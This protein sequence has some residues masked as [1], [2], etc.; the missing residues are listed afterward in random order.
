LDNVKNKLKKLLV[1]ENEDKKS[2]EILERITSIDEDK[3]QSLIKQIS[4]L[5]TTPL[6]FLRMNSEYNEGDNISGRIISM[7]TDYQPIQCDILIKSDDKVFFQGKTNE[8]GSLEF[9]FKANQKKYEVKAIF[10]GAERALVLDLE[11]K[12]NDYVCYVITDKDYYIPGQKILVRVILWKLIGSKYQPSTEPIKIT[13]TDPQ[14]NIILYREISCEPKFGVAELQIPIT[15]EAIQGDYTLEIKV[16]DFESQKKIHIKHYTPPDIELEVECEPEYL[17]IGDKFTFKLKSNYFYGAPVKDGQ[18]KI[19]IIASDS[20]EVLKNYVKTDEKGEHEYNFKVPKMKKGKTEIRV[21]LTDSLNRKASKTIILMALEKAMNVSIDMEKTIEPGQQAEIIVKTE[22]PAL[23]NKTKPLQDCQILATIND[24]ELKHHAKFKMGRTDKEGRC[25][26]IFAIDYPT[27]KKKNFDIN[28]TIE[29]EKLNETTYIRKGLTVQKAIKKEEKEEKLDKKPIDIWLKTNLKSSSLEINEILQFDVSVKREN[30]PVYVEIEKEN[31]IYRAEK[32]AKQG[33]AT[34]E[35]PISRNMWGNLNLV[36][37]AFKENGVLEK[38]QKTLYI[39]PE[40][41]ELKITIESDQPE[42]RPGDKAKF[43]VRVSQ[44]DE[45]MACCLGAMLVDAAVLQLGRKLKNP[46]EIFFKKLISKKQIIELISWSKSEYH[47]NFNDLLDALILHIQQNPKDL[48]ILLNFSRIVQNLHLLKHEDFMTIYEKI[49]KCVQKKAETY[50]NENKMTLIYNIL[51]TLALSKP[52]IEEIEFIE[53]SA[54]EELSLISNENVDLYKAI[55]SDIKLAHKEGFLTNEQKEEISIRVHERAL[56][57]TPRKTSALAPELKKQINEMLEWASNKKAVENL[58]SKYIMRLKNLEKA[59]P[60]DLKEPTGKNIVLALGSDLSYIG[61]AGE[62]APRSIVP[63]LVGYPKYTS[64]MTDVEHYAREFYVG[65]EALSLR[66]GYLLPILPGSTGSDV[67]HESFAGGSEDSL[68]TVVTKSLSGEITQAPMVSVRFHFPETSLWIPNLE[69]TNGEA[70]IETEL[71]DQITSHELTIIA[72]TKECEAGIGTY[73]ATVKQNFF[74][75]LDTPP[76]LTHGD[77]IKIG[78]ILTNLTNS[79]LESKVHLKSDDQILKIEKLNDEI[80]VPANGMNRLDFKIKAVSPGQAVLWIEAKTS[81]YIDVVRKEIKVNPKGE[82]H[83]IRYTGLITEDGIITFSPQIPENTIFYRAHLSL[84]PGYLMGCIDGLESILEYPHGCTEQ[85]MAKFLPNILVYNLLKAKEKITAEFQKKIN[86]YTII[87]IQQ[88][89]SLRNENGGWGYWGNR[90]TVPYITAHVIYSLAYAINS[91]FFIDQKILKNAI[92]ELGK[93]QTKDGIWESYG[94][95]RNFST[96][97]VV[98]A[99]LEAKKAGLSINQ[100][101]I[102]KAIK[103]IL[104]QISSSSEILDDPNTMANI[105]EVLLD[106]NPKKYQKQVEFLIERIIELAKRENAYIYWEKGSA[107]AG[108]VESTANVVIALHL[109]NKDPVLIQ[110]ALNYIMLK[111]SGYGWSTTSDTV[112]AIR[113]LTKCVKSE[114]QNFSLKVDFNDRQVGNYIVNKD[115]IESIIYDMRKI[116]LKDFSTKNKLVLEKKGEG[117]VVYD[118]NIETWHPK[119]Y[120][121]KSEVITITRD[122]NTDKINKNDSIIVKIN[123][124]TTQNQ[125]MFVIEDPIPAGFFVFEPSLKKLIEE[126]K[127]VSYKLTKEK[128]NLYLEELK[129]SINLSYRIISTNAGE[130]IAKETVAYPMYNVALKTNSTIKHLT[131]N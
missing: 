57:A 128:I 7:D 108:N 4:S 61:F 123:V 11:K 130:I 38:D 45:L 41:K 70:V 83:I 100:E 3:I 59:I 73:R 95:N 120:L 88:L 24:S 30:I 129:G 127:I 85:T 124:S 111:R 122:Y 29:S 1:I 74:I 68:S 99:L 114:N 104:T 22:I 78:I 117:M 55:I 66:G 28:L 46:L 96:I 54:N 103:K 32:M 16:K 91:G 36:T 25:T 31:I 64:I 48:G 115:N 131:I 89:L 18:A 35:I 39:N 81:K 118:L 5:N 50:Q 53:Q 6:I 72:S 93:Y 67:V 34:F 21:E 76:I 77:N 63:T 90:N 92:I 27:E 110:R 121:L 102:K 26:I 17:K 19:E 80:L 60:N 52:P 33:K 79:D 84:I 12:D 20:T 106:F 43:T 56:S 47:T 58:N 87:G 125:G 109:T 86:E 2:L 116:P 9:N 119:E 71:P 126:Q 98:K 105:V 101:Q 69:T 14:K 40:G 10:N 75:Q 42:Y 49:I 97:Y 51:K 112:A 113:C 44:N 13:L 23:K 15:E 82:P 8:L 107:L 62:D 65:E 37:Y 94:I